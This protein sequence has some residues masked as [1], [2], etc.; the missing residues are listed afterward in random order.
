MLPHIPHVVELLLLERYATYCVKVAENC[1]LPRTGRLLRLLA[2]DLSLERDNH[3][4]LLMAQPRVP[5]IA[6]F[7]ASGG[8]N[9]RG[10][11]FQQSHH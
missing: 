4:R 7:L 9:R 8:Q 11:R 2:A 1:K 10:D 5:R 3:Y 6:K